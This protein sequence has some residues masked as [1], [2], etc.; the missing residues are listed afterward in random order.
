MDGTVNQF[1]EMLV[2]EI[3]YRFDAQNIPDAVL[4]ATFLNPGFDNHPFFEGTVLRGDTLED[5]RQYARE[6]VFEALQDFLSMGN[7]FGVPNPQEYGP[8]DWKRKFEHEITSYEAD[9]MDGS[10]VN[11]LFNPQDWWRPRISTFPCLTTLARAYF[12]I[13]ASSV[14]SERL[15]SCA[16]R[17][18]TPKREKTDD[19]LFCRQ[20]LIKSIHAFDSYIPRKK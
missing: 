6:Q 14:P 13:Q 1:R 3:E 18:L 8:A 16:G 20:V 15:F 17:Y 2:G 5:M 12:S 10:G 19:S 11:Y 9:L 7:H 4:V